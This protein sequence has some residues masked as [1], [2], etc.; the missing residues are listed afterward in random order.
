MKGDYV[1]LVKNTRVFVN[2]T[3]ELSLS[4]NCVNISNKV[5][6]VSDSERFLVDVIAKMS[7]CQLS[8]A[9]TKSIPHGKI[10]NH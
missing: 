10:H 9:R 7:S 5:N 2:H 8:L 6:I 1:S 4:E 3:V